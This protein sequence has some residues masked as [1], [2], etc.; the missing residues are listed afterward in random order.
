MNNFIL[1]AKRDLNGGV[2]RE[3]DKGKITIIP[4]GYTIQVPSPTTGSS[5]KSEDVERVLL[6]LGFGPSVAYSA[7]C[8]GTWEVT[9]L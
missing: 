9:K 3:K 8:A 2:V 5:P 4:K 6:A 1:K 7:R